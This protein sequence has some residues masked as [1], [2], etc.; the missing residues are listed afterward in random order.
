MI[1]FSSNALCSK[2]KAMYGKKITHEKY[3]SLCRRQ[4]VGEVVSDLKLEDSYDIVFNG[5]NEKEI[6]RDEIER[7]LNQELIERCIKLMKYAP[8]KHQEFYLKPLMEIEIN[9]IIDKISSILFSINSNQ[10]PMMS[11][12]AASRCSFD[13]NG[14]INITTYQDLIQ[15]LSHTKYISILKKYDLDHYPL[16]FEKLKK[17]LKEFYYL[18]YQQTIMNHF[19]GNT[20]R[21]LLHILYTTV[22]LKN[23]SSIYR[24]KKYFPNS[25]KPIEDVLFL[26]F[27]RLPNSFLRSLIQAPDASSVLRLLNQSSYHLYL[28]DKDEYVYI[29]YYMESIRY[30]IAKRF[31]RFSSNAALVYM[32]YHMIHKV[33]VDNLK[34]IIEG[35]RYQRQV[36]SISEMLIEV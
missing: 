20:R 21:R 25:T 23:I 12:T 3:L 16:A 17:E 9:F 31:M 10:V 26:S 6:H 11:K 28:D 4:S 2:A 22:E 15:Y 5:V 33:E 19:K 30:D 7:L 8:K 13:V 27:N 32:T 34:H 1:D 14:F 18:D 29:E 36:E 24:R 35:I